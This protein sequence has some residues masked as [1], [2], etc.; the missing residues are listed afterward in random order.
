MLA[1]LVSSYIHIR[2]V[3]F[4]SLSFEALVC[5]DAVSRSNVLNPKNPVP[6]FKEVKKK[7]PQYTW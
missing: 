3:G 2:Q 1:N 6:S 4:S 7:L 5:L